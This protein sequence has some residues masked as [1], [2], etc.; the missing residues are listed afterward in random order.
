MQTNFDNE[1][2]ANRFQ[3]ELQKSGIE[4][5]LKKAGVRPGDTVKIGPVEL[6]WEPLEDLR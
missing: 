1:E 3:R 2:S 6:E 5:A 4:A